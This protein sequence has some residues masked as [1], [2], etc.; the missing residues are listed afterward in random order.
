MAN[1]ESKYG[2]ADE[3]VYERTMWGEV[4]RDKATIKE[5]AFTSRG[6][7]YY[8]TEDEG[9]IFEREIVRKADALI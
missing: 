7:I 5:V 1:F 6:S 9:L 4:V 8:T 2:I 3:V